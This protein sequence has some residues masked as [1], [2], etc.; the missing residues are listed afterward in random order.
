[1]CVCVFIY[2][3]IYIHTY[4]YTYI[5]PCQKSL[6]S[7][8]DKLKELFASLGIIFACPVEHLI[9]LVAWAFVLPVWVFLLVCH[10]AGSTILGRSQSE[11][12]TCMETFEFVLGL[13]LKFVNCLIQRQVNFTFN[14]TLTGR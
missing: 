1:M 9:C 7:I 14:G 11:T 12:T 4:T 3:Y 2:I 8:V 13:N 10:V 6:C 5:C